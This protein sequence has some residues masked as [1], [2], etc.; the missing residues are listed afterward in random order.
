M[1]YRVLDLER[2]FGIP[3]AKEDEHEIWHMECK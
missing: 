1:L 2:F 3:Q